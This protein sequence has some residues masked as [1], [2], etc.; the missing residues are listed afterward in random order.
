M[1]EKISQKALQWSPKVAM[2][3][4]GKYLQLRV[5]T[6]SQPLHADIQLTKASDKRTYGYTKIEG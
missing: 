1:A 2:K 4:G 3:M 6:D 5:S